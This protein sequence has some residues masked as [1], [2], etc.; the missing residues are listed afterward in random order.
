MYNFYKQRILHKKIS[1][2]RWFKKESGRLIPVI[3]DSSLEE[4]RSW[5]PQGPS[6]GRSSSGIIK[7]RHGALTITSVAVSQR[8]VYLCNA[9]NSEGSDFQEVSVVIVSSLKI[10]LYVSTNKLTM[11]ATRLLFTLPEE[12][13][14]SRHQI[15]G[16]VSS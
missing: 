15:N 11:N 6:T 1:H 2:F 8:G 4:L 12:K 9:S 5:E 14:E 7:I 16:S 3:D 10:Q 13:C